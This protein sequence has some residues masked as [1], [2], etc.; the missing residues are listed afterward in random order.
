MLMES[1]ITFLT[2]A[3]VD[4]HVLVVLKKKG[5]QGVMVAN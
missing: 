2:G 1:D 4:E 3:A 5:S